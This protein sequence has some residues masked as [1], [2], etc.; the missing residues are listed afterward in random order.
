MNIIKSKVNAFI[1]KIYSQAS[2]GYSIANEQI[3]EVVNEVSK[4][5]PD[6]S[7]DQAAEMLKTHADLISAVGNFLMQLGETAKTADLKPL[8]RG[9]A[10]EIQETASPLYTIIG[11]T[12]SKLSTLFAERAKSDSPIGVGISEFVSNHPIKATQLYTGFNAITK[13]IDAGKTE[14]E[15]IH[16]R[17]MQE[18]SKARAIESLIEIGCPADSVDAHLVA[19]KDGENWWGYRTSPIKG[20]S[21]HTRV[22][23]E[24]A[25]KAKESMDAAAIQ[26]EIDRLQ[27]LISEQQQ[28]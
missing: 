12:S 23:Q 22:T 27:G 13:A 4:P 18:Y 10:G 28:G 9:I 20:S 25:I 5:V 24:A 8:L 6:K 16:N 3:N 1:S 14:R 26:A 2:E 15:A 11:E 19:P 7:I 21:W 17:E